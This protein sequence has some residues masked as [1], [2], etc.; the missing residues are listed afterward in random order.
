M[1]PSIYWLLQI[2]RLPKSL[3]YT[4]SGVDCNNPYTNC[5]RPFRLTIFKIHIEKWHT[6]TSLETSLHGRLNIN[7]NDDGSLICC[8]HIRSASHLIQFIN[9]LW[10]KL[11]IIRCIRSSSSSIYFCILKP[12]SWLL[13]MN[14]WIWYWSG[15]RKTKRN[16]ENSRSSGNKRVED[17]IILEVNGQ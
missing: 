2:M 13:L 10:S 9:Q 14:V 11:R 17:S 5:H 7:N 15:F 3:H 4:L 1:A 12:Q 6:S 8:V 16:V